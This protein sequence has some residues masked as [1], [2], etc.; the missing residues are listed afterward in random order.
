M[1]GGRIPLKQI[2]EI[3]GK[4]R[5]STSS[6]TY[7]PTMEN[8]PNHSK[9]DEKLMADHQLTGTRPAEEEEELPEL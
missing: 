1:I 5:F 4:F 6:G 3:K 9:P 7:V 8:L 2:D